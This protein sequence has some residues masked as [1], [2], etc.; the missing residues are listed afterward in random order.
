MNLPSK[1]T[2]GTNWKPKRFGTKEID[3][4]LLNFQRRRYLLMLYLVGIRHGTYQSGVDWSATGLYVELLT[5]KYVMWQGLW[6][7]VIVDRSDRI[8]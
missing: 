3:V 5:M 7:L 8:K 6:R 4:N 2:S 1:N